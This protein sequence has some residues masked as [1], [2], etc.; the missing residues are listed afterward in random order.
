MTRFPPD[1]FWGAATSAYQVEGGNIH[2]D[3]WP[4]EKVAGKEQSGQACRHYELYEQD[5]DLAKGLG[6]NAHRLSVE[7]ARIE[8]EEG[9][10]SEKELQHYVDVLLALKKRG[11]EPV[12]TL[13]HFTNP[14]WFTQS[15]GW[16]DRRAVGRFLRF[17]DVVVRKL[18][19]HVHFW[20]TINEPTIYFSHS[21]LFGAWPPQGRSFWR[22]KAVHGNLA[23][24]HVETYRLIHQVY[25]AAE[26]PKPAVSI[27]QHMSAVVACQSNVRNDLAVRLRDHFY[28]FE[29]LDRLMRPGTLD[30]IGVNYYSRNLV[31]TSAWW[32]DKLF[33]ETCQ[34]G[35]HSVK[36]NSL[37]WDIYP[38]GLGQV[39]VKLKRYDLPVMITENGIC[40]SD[41]DLRWEFLSAHLRSIR[42]AMDQG[43]KVTGYLYW[44][45]L[46]NFEWDKGFGPRFGLIDVDYKTYQRTVRPS[47]V[48]FAEVC[49]T[50][51]LA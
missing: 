3:W 38:E 14:I 21:F 27:S 51:T 5:F 9:C 12:V 45:L 33:M 11:I 19:P 35:H 26:L 2:S 36:K 28:N 8:P 29:F 23:K 4:W 42:L 37:G 43:V 44:S 17:C 41:D 32:I 50:G 13:H 10:F 47:A 18:S 25:K 22:M 48:K 15:G 1:F 24:A 30:F 7:W 46:D 16:E 49:K 6:H 39:L 40:T 34:K 31:D 20:I